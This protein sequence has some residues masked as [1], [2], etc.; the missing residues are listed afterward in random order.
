MMGDLIYPLLMIVNQWRWMIVENTT[1][2]I[3]DFYVLRDN[4]PLPRRSS[5]VFNLLA[6]FLQTNVA[7]RVERFSL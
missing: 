3:L 7:L 6:S 2:L 4:G 5:P 1:S